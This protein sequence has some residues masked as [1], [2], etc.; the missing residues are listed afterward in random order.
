MKLLLDTHVWLWSLLEPEHLTPRVE[1]ALRSAENELWL[2]PIS[3]WETMQLLQRRRL[4]V[5][6]DR[7]SWIA[8]ML[9]ASALNEAP[10]TH[11]VAIEAVRIRLSHRDPA[12]RFLAASAKVHGLTLV[13]ADKRLLGSKD[14]ASLDGR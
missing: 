6:I 8:N 12:D 3:V 10:F 9:H 2:S 7:S 14:F 11:D 5:P 13:T 1:A 4:E